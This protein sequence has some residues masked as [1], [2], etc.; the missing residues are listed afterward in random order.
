MGRR[1][2]TVV[3]FA[4]VFAFAIAVGIYTKT[5][6]VIPGLASTV[7]NEP[8]FLILAIGL[9]SLVAYGWSLTRRPSRAMLVVRQ[10]SS[11]EPLSS[12]STKSS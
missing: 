7:V 1:V 3:F 12:E 11:T 2:V 8:L 4:S 6:N 10:E 9:I 5:L